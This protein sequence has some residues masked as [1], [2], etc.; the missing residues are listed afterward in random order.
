M[1]I[2]N[3]SQWLG[4]TTCFRNMLTCKPGSGR[5]WRVT[6]Q[7][8][9]ISLT[10]HMPRKLAISLVRPHASCIEIRFTHTHLNHVADTTF[11]LK[12]PESGSLSNKIKLNPCHSSC[13]YIF[14]SNTRAFHSNDLFYAAAILEGRLSSFLLCFLGKYQR[15]ANTNSN[16]T[17][18]VLW[19]CF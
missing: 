6:S 17:I 13:L 19:N 9:G 10:C 12:M 16:A 15:E 8:F 3:C 11:G 1:Y 2:Y 18:T 5:R 7:P 4:W 14:V